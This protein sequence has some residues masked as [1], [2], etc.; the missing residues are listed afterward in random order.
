MFLIFQVHRAYM[1]ADM[2]PDESI[3]Q[4]VISLGD[5][6][7]PEIDFA[8]GGSGPH[9]LEKPWKS[10][11]LSKIEEIHSWKVF[12]FFHVQHLHLYQEILQ[13]GQT[14]YSK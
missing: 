10:L 5:S 6:D 9:I 12:K 8:E 11:N 13:Q 3:V 1:K 14:H 2:I 4:E 7:D